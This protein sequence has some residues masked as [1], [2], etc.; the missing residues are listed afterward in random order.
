MQPQVFPKL[1]VIKMVNAKK[2][3]KR[4]LM[5]SQ[6]L[7]QGIQETKQLHVMER[8]VNTKNIRFGQ[9]ATVKLSVLSI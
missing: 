2:R 5:Q 3:N 6:N 9:T 4:F 7:A 8:T 1:R